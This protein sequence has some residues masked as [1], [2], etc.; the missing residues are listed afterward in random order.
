[1]NGKHFGLA[2]LHEDLQAPI[3]ARRFGSGW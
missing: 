3:E 2:A 1:M